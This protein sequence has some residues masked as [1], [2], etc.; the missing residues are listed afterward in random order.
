MAALGDAYSR[1]YDPHGRSRARAGG[2]SFRGPGA[3]RRGPPAGHMARS[4][5]ENESY[6]DDMHRAYDLGPREPLRARVAP[7]GPLG[8][9][10]TSSAASG[11]G[12]GRS[13]GPPELPNL[14]DAWAS[15]PADPEGVAVDL[16]H[17]PVLCSAVDP[18]RRRVALGC[19]DHAVYELS[20][21]TGAVTRTLHSK[22]YGHAEW[23]TSVA[24][25]ADGTLASAA[26]DSKI[27]VWAPSGV[28]CADMTGHSSSISAL[29]S[30]GQSI[31]SAGYDHTVRVWSSRSCSETA[32][33]A[34]H[35]GPVLCIAVDSTSRAVTGGRDSLACAWDIEAGTRIGRMGGHSGHV[36]ASC[37]LRDGFSS[38]E[39]AGGGDMYATGAQD[40]HVRVWDLRARRAVANVPVHVSDD[41]AGAVGD[42]GL[43]TAT[44]PFD[45]VTSGADRSVCV[46]DSRRGFCVRSRLTEHKDFVYS[47]RV[48]GRIALSGAGDGTLIAHDVV[49]GRPLWALGANEAAVRCIE[50]DGDTVLASGDDGNAIVYKSG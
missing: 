24:Y 1:K 10:A 43:C 7:G 8:S 23:V 11:A 17:R 27:C 13:S 12:A 42:I 4:H 47:L 9:R 25:L 30:M 20:L 35:R 14:A 49:A 5:E 3:A 48:A 31:I 18:A 16:S 50:C 15:G 39:G 34:G 45:L 2:P 28:R 21:D 36:T 22:R 33:L 38:G 44:S 46:M 29:A 41:G 6:M 19:S 40:G 26:M 37:W 32:V